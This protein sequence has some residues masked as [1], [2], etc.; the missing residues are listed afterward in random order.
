VGVAEGALE[1]WSTGMDGTEAVE[2]PG[3]AAGAIPEAFQV[4]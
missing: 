2:W 3:L 1:V 4:K